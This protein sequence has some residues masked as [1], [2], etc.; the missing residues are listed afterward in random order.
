MYSSAPFPPPTP[1]FPPPSEAHFSQQKPSKPASKSS[2]FKRTRTLIRK[3]TKS[4][5]DDPNSTITKNFIAY[6]QSLGPICISL[7]SDPLL[8]NPKL[9]IF[10]IKGYHTVNVSKKNIPDLSLFLSK[11]SLSIND[12]NVKSIFK[13]GLLQYLSFISFKKLNYLSY[14]SNLILSNLSPISNTFTMSNPEISQP[15]SSAT[16]PFLNSS[17]SYVDDESISD[18]LKINL[19]G[20]NIDNV[21]SSMKEVVDPNFSNIIKNSDPNLVKKNVYI[22]VIVLGHE[23][24]PLDSYPI[25][26]SL[27]EKMHNPFR[28]DIIQSI[29]H[30]SLGKSLS[31]YHQN[32]SPNNSNRLLST[33]PSNKSDSIKKNTVKKYISPIKSIAQRKSVAGGYFLSESPIPQRRKSERDSL[34]SDKSI[35]QKKST[36]GEYLSFETP[37]PQK[38]K[39]ARESLTSD[40]SITQRGNVIKE[41]ISSE[42]SYLSK[43][44][45][46]RQKYQLPLLKS[47]NSRDNNWNHA[48]AMRV[49]F[50]NLFQILEVNRN[51]FIDLKSQYNSFVPSKNNVFQVGKI[52]NFHFSN[53]LVYERYISG[54]LRAIKMSNSLS[55]KSHYYASFLENVRANN[56]FEKLDINGLLIFP[57]QR[58]PRYALLIKQLLKTTSPDSQ[59]YL[60][61][62]E[63]LSKINSIGNLE[64]DPYSSPLL[65]LTSRLNKSKSTYRSSSRTSLSLSANKSLN[66]LKLANLNS[67]PPPPLPTNSITSDQFAQSSIHEKLLENYTKKSINQSFTELYKL[68]SSIEGCP[69]SLISSKRVL[70]AIINASESSIIPRTNG[71]SQPS[72]DPSA[73]NV[74]SKPEN[75]SGS[76]N[77]ISQYLFNEPK[78]PPR[79]EQYIHYNYLDFPYEPNPSWS[80]LNPKPDE[81]QKVSIVV[82]SDSIMIV[83]NNYGVDIA[84]IFD[85]LS[86]KSNT[87]IV[88][89][90]GSVTD[91]EPDNVKKLGFF[92]TW[93]HFNQIQMLSNA[94]DYN[95]LSFILHKK[96]EKLNLLQNL[97]FGKSFY[98]QTLYDTF[99]ISK[100]LINHKFN[101][102]NSFSTSR[103]SLAIR[104]LKL[105]KMYE[106]L[107]SNTLNGDK[108]NPL[109]LSQNS[110]FSNEQNHSSQNPDQFSSKSDI[111][112]IDP[113]LGPLLRSKSHELAG[114][115]TGINNPK[116][117]PRFENKGAE[118]FENSNFKNFTQRF[119]LDDY[120]YP[121]GL[122][123][124]VASNKTEY[125][126]LVV[127]FQLVDILEEQKSAEN[128]ESESDDIF[129]AESRTGSV[130]YS[131]QNDKFRRLVVVRNNQNWTFRFW[132][133]DDFKTSCKENS[134]PNPDSSIVINISGTGN[135][136]S[137]QTLV[138]GFSS[139]TLSAISDIEKSELMPT[140]STWISLLEE[141]DSGSREG[142]IQFKISKRPY[143]RRSRNKSLIEK[144]DFSGGSY[145]THPHLSNNGA[146]V[147]FKE[148]SID[149]LSSI[150]AK[151]L[152]RYM[153][154]QKANHPLSCVQSFGYCQSYISEIFKGID[155]MAMKKPNK[156]IFS[157]Y[158]PTSD[159]ILGTGSR[160]FY[161]LKEKGF[162]PNRTECFIGTKN[163]QKSSVMRAKTNSFMPKNKS[164]E[165]I[166]LITHEISKGSESVK[167]IDNLANNEF[168]KE[169]ENGLEEVIQIIS[170]FK[171]DNR[172]NQKFDFVTKS[173]QNLRDDPINGKIFNIVKEIIEKI[174]TKNEQPKHRVPIFVISGSTT[175]NDIFGHDSSGQNLSPAFGTKSRIKIQGRKISIKTSREL[176]KYDCEPILSIGIKEFLDEE[177]VGATDIELS[178]ISI[179]SMLILS[180]YLAFEKEFAANRSGVITASMKDYICS[181]RKK[182]FTKRITKSF[183]N[184]YIKELDLNTDSFNTK[185]SPINFDQ[186]ISVSDLMNRS[187]FEIGADDKFILSNVRSRA[188]RMIRSSASIPER[189]YNGPISNVDSDQPHV[190]LTFKEPDV[191]SQEG[192]SVTSTSKPDEK[193]K[194][195]NDN[196]SEDLSTVR[197]D[198]SCEFADNAVVGV[199]EFLEQTKTWRDSDVF[200]CVG[201]SNF[202]EKSLEFETEEFDGRRSVFDDSDYVFV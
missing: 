187:A 172:Y 38:R 65:P 105:W 100:E 8:Q 189:F 86:S 97:R 166:Q 24:L 35:S 182:L 155:N 127:A 88:I 29:S 199:F 171:L 119:K 109:N 160:S 161:S 54:Y 134:R 197:H 94:L 14:S 4:S 84:S 114:E 121:S 52:C 89:D 16:F 60:D 184:G 139:K 67:T 180:T 13:L 104:R 198:S 17:T 61:L 26:L 141:G 69:S 103:E 79:Q 135:E 96:S 23:P 190:E 51:F 148:K 46:L 202:E 108:K 196:S 169:V 131:L 162:E 92:Q 85:P 195:V 159:G 170:R 164:A 31:T 75:S 133:W 145:P 122:H 173:A 138:E 115:Y 82:F 165:P 2:E 20:I 158:Q 81:K 57:A 117:I 62:V 167:P 95:P 30:K 25:Y 64:H 42:E 179:C 176:Q 98:P 125:K 5:K 73:P 33:T 137:T 178:V 147:P 3:E 40:K 10:G 72:K 144:F 112:N 43:L 22:D 116:I 66:D 36:A 102:K 113:L 183:S 39:S 21:F 191:T 128:C 130:F 53:F 201:N 45:F 152:D 193:C 200:N 149:E 168:G 7:S 76:L 1:S 123:R 9:L 107:L 106:S 110:S 111:I 18:F 129:V 71:I 83:K 27:F 118:S 80:H 55:K 157:I 194:C 87:S 156:S 99:N 146:N 93:I 68:C 34:T 181:S 188:I 124:F 174:G 163:C 58:I 126:K 192:L 11:S 44:D 91:N 132:K 48:Y 120:W 150:I 41:L 185:Q 136:K 143:L 70:I 74:S 151:N 63:S 154:D 177:T 78:S 15:N 56:T 32:A 140:F 90:D 47:A 59:E 186:S 19:L 6:D 37:V 50:G 142:N 28:P 12:C 153:I 101:P 77:R 49:I 175:F